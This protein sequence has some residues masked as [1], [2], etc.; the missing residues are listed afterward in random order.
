MVNFDL[1]VPVK[2]SPHQI[3]NIS[4]IP[5][6]F[7]VSFGICDP[8]VLSLLSSSIPW[9]TAGLLLSLSICLYFLDFYTNGIIQYVLIKIWFL[10]PS[11]IIFRFILDVACINSFFLCYWSIVFLCVDRIYLLM[12]IRVV[13]SLGL[14]QSFRGFPCP[15]LCMDIGFYFSWV[16]T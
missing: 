6:S 8:S 2:P 1:Y 4:I 10:S 12:N 7:L 16:N 14:V 3:M 13:S 9:A 11:M 5:Q 15:S